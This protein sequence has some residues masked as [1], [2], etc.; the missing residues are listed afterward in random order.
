MFREGLVFH[1]PTRNVEPTGELS[2]SVRFDRGGQTR[3]VHFFG[4]AGESRVVLTLVVMLVDHVL[5]L[6]LPGK[7]FRSKLHT[8]RVSVDDACGDS[9]FE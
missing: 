9:H 4:D 5:R 1:F 6:A 2:C 8:N 7:E 3:K